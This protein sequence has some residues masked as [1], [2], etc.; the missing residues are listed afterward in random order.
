M[1]WEFAL[2]W[3]LLNAAEV[4]A[5]AGTHPDDGLPSIEWGNLRQGAERPAIVL[6]LVSD[7]RPITHEGFDSI[8]RSRI[9]VQVQADTRL[10]VINLREA[11]IAELAPAGRF[12]PAS[13]EVWFDHS[14]FELV[15]DIGGQTATGFVHADSVD[16][17]VTHKG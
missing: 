10:A 17:I 16:I 7:P 12:G 3:R 8:R 13:G 14:E 1:S 15:R 6:K 9:R 5:L 2:R 11:L 4:T